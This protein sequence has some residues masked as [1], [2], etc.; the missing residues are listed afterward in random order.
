MESFYH[1][2]TLNDGQ[3]FL[4]IYIVDTFRYELTGTLSANEQLW[5]EQLDVYVKKSLF[6]VYM[7]LIKD[8][9]EKIAGRIHIQVSEREVSRSI[10]SD[11]R[12]ADHTL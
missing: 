1:G 2:R 12:I 8:L 11:Y 10:W 5:D 6:R 4:V 7:D 9:P 3:V